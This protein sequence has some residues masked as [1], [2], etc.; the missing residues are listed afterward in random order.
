MHLTEQEVEHYRSQLTNILQHFQS[1]QNIDT[2]GVE[3]TGHATD[4]NTVLRDDEAGAPLHREQ[5]LANAPAVNGE[6]IRVRA[7]MDSA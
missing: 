3:P 5:V 7:V 1:L 6:F 4:V 2:T